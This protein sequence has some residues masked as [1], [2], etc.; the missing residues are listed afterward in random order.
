M[1]Y[2]HFALQLAQCDEGQR[3]CDKVAAAENESHASENTKQET[4]CKQ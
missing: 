4:S 2:F 3:Y 1:S